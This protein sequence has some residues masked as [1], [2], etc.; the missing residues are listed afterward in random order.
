MQVDLYI[1]LFIEHQK[2]LKR[3]LKV[4]EEFEKKFVNEKKVFS[5]FVDEKIENNWPKKN[6]FKFSHISKF[7]TNYKAL[8]RALSHK[9]LLITLSSERTIPH[10]A[11]G[12]DIVKFIN[13]ITLDYSGNNYFEKF[14]SDTDRLI[15]FDVNTWKFWDNY[16]EIKKQNIQIIDKNFLLFFSA[17]NFY[18]ILFYAL[19]YFNDFRKGFKRINE[20]KESQVSL[21][22][23]LYFCYFL[24]LYKTVF[25]EVDFLKVIFTTSNSRSVEYL[26]HSL[27]GH[28]SCKNIVEFLHGVPTF[29][30]APYFKT[31]SEA[32]N[33]HR[34]LPLIRFQNDPLKKYLIPESIINLN[35]SKALFSQGYVFPINSLGKDFL[36][37]EKKITDAFYKLNLKN[38]ISVV[39]QIVGNSSHEA[40]Y[41]NSSIFFLECY[42]ID[43][44]YA[45]IKEKNKEMVLIYCPHPL[46]KAINFQEHPFFKNKAIQIIN[47]TSVVSFYSDITISI[48]STSVFEAKN[49][50]VNVFTP[51]SYDDRMYGS[52]YLNYLKSNNTVTNLED[53]IKTCFKNMDIEITTDLIGRANKRLKKMIT[54]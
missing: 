33:K 25:A 32:H 22:N 47:E 1:K 54:R 14:K 23:Y 36:F 28:E 50:G 2:A 42:L 53:D 40:D 43:K 44:F 27:L 41:L 31:L 20:N 38:N 15:L 21:K 46:R 51:I 39:V 11:G 52:E 5:T 37:N 48:L 19:K 17:L 3:N 45:L 13:E 12:K 29:D 30:F 6:K 16:E 9:P 18:K 10:K 34:L 4:F 49:I 8:K 24:C 26:R 7:F 35:M